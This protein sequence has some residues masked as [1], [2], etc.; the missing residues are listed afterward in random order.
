MGFT[1]LCNKNIYSAFNN[2]A[3]SP[4]LSEIGLSF[5]ASNRFLLGDVNQLSAALVF[6]NTKS[7]C[8]SG[9]F[10]F[11]GYSN[12]NESTL[13]FAYARKFGKYI[14]GGLKLNYHRLFILDNGSTN[15]VSFNT[16][17]LVHPTEKL[18]IGIHIANPVKQKLNKGLK[19]TFNSLFA[20]G[21]AY[22]ANDKL[23]L[24]LEAH[25]N[26]HYPL[27]LKFG[28][29]YKIHQMFSLRL[30]MASAPLLFTGGVGLQLKAFTLD[31]ASTW[32]L[33]LG[34]SPQLSLGYVFKKKQE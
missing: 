5:Y 26:F 28:M 13:G 9:T 21:V 12:Y 24:N 15:L 29:D 27:S 11:D 4:F 22:N 25:K 23:Q 20:F 6:P 30:G 17:L 7:S 1:G 34:Y 32:N 33:K 14:S 8:F 10:N 16:D 2:T 18:F 3:A 31:L 19:E